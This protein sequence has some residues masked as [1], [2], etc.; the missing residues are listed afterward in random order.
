MGPCLEKEAEGSS[1]MAYSDNQ[2]INI[3]D[4]HSVVKISE[5]CSDIY[6][7]SDYKYLTLNIGEQ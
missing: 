3:L 2:L 5:R 6:L 7:V 4:A 1:E